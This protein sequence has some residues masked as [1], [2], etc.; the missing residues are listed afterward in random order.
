[1]KP[2]EILNRFRAQFGDETPSRTE[3]YDGSKSFEEGREV[4]NMRRLHLL[5]GKL[6]PAF[7]CDS[8]GVFFIDFLIEQRTIIAT[9]CSQLPEDW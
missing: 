6:G 7:F 4:E 2:S 9:Y 8:Q 1:V 5:Q 3:I